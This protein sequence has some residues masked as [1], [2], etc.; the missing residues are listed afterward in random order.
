MQRSLRDVEFCVFEVLYAL[1][2]SGA[3]RVA[4]P[5]SKDAFST[6]PRGDVA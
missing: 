1:A 6:L 5:A 4:K 2:L 3:T